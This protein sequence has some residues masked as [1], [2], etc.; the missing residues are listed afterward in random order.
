MF[1]DVEVV[2]KMVDNN[3]IYYLLDLYDEEIIKDVYGK[4]ICVKIMG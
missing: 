4:I 1:K 2:I 3:I